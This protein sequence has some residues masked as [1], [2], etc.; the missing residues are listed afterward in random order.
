MACGLYSAHVVN[1]DDARRTTGNATQHHADCVDV[2]V[3]RNV[4]G[5][6]SQ[7]PADKG[8]TAVCEDMKLNFRQIGRIWVLG[9]V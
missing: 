7:L 9:A 8:D 4:E 6:A 5:H 2:S 3:K 1:V